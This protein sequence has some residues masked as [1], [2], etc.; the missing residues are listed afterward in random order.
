VGEPLGWHLGELAVDQAAVAGLLRP[1][2]AGLRSFAG[3]PARTRCWKAP[4]KLPVCQQQKQKTPAG[5]GFGV[6]IEVDT[7]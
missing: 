3:L 6:M 1:Q 7:A 4:T 5:P 2:G